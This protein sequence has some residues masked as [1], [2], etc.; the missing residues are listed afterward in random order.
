MNADGT[1]DVISP[2]TQETYCTWPRNPATSM[3]N[4]VTAT[5]FTLPPEGGVVYVQNV[6]T[7]G[8]NGEPARRARFSQPAIGGNGGSG[9]VPTRAHPL[10]F[11]Q[12]NDITPTSSQFLATGYGCRN[13]DAFVEG[14]LNGR[15]TIG[16]QNNIIL[17]GSTTY[18]GTDD[19]LG[20]V[21]NNYISVYHP[22]TDTTGNEFA[23]EAGTISLSGFDAAGVSEVQRLTLSNWGSGDSLHAEVP[24]P[25]EAPRAASSGTRAIAIIRQLHPR[26]SSR[27]T[28]PINSGDIS[29][30]V[31]GSHQFTIT[32]S[33]QYTNTNVD[34]IVLSCTNCSG[35]TMSTVTP[36][37]TGDQFRL[38]F[39]G[40]Q[41]GPISVGAASATAV[42]TALEALPNI[43]PGD[44]TVTGP[45]NGPYTYT[46]GGQYAYETVTD[47]QI[48]CTGCTGSVIVT[49]QGGAGTDALACDPRECSRA[50]TATCGCRGPA[51]PRPPLRSSADRR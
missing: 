32:F 20:L 12:K 48:S 10:G 43:A 39:G 28:R 36:G 50:R 14:Q 35:S 2:F 26:P 25:A 40:S 41:T 18:A 47:L 44:V 33:E 1:M 29:V 3:H 49:Q 42:Q 8:I 27:T 19:L 37:S 45:D 17:V 9:S 4:R 11:P 21:A 31:T 46:F 38:T 15:L 24:Q 5:T 6:P 23:N 30:A 34:Q 16:A 22:V 13:G 51:R 7:S